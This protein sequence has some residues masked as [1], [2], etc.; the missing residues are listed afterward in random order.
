MIRLSSLVGLTCAGFTSVAVLSAGSWSFVRG[1]Q[2]DGT[3]PE[4]IPATW[5]AQGPKVLWRVPSQKGFSSF[6]VADGRAFTLELREVEGA[7]QEVLV[8]RNADTG[9]ELWVKALGAVKYQGGGDSGTSDNK[10]G[11]GPRSTPTISGDRVYVTSAKLVLSCF[12]AKSGS[13]VWQQDLL[14]D[15]GGKNISWENAASP[16]VEEGLV[17]VAGGGAGQSLVAFNATDGKVVWK[18]FDETMT[19]ATPTPATIHGQRQVI[20]FVKSGLLSVEPKTGKEL[21]RYSFPFRVSTAASP[22]VAGDIVYCSAGYGV[23][24]GACKVSKDGTAWTAK[25]IYRFSGDKPLAN[26]WSTP[27]LHDGHL[28]GMFQFKEYGDGPVK[29]VDVATGKVNWEKPGFGPGHVILAGNQ[30]LA[31][32]DA[33]QLVLIEATPSGYRELARADVLDGKC[34]TTPVLS[35]GRIYA[36]STKEAVC[37]DFSG[38]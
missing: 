27:V 24:A 36:R 28:Y 29:C 22:V 3:T 32:G 23:G 33:G 19:H 16:L 5:P 4:K 7:P 11:D 38:K 25:E 17:L 15:F 14:K 21:W 31:L 37:L 30:V 26:H 20:F 18:A 2:G 35:N 9:A 8:A 12:D 13:L 10:G 34:W 1:P 6:S